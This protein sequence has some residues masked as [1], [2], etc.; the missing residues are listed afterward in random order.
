MTMIAPR[1]WP[2]RIAF[3]HRTWHG[4]IGV[5]LRAFQA[6]R[7]STRG[8][9]IWRRR[10]PSRL[11]VQRLVTQM[12]RCMTTLLVRQAVGAPGESCG[13]L[14]ARAVSL[15]VA[16]PSSRTLPAAQ[17]ATP[18]WPGPGGMAPT[19]AWRDRPARA[20]LGH[21][22]SGTPRAHDIV[23]PRA[24]ASGG[25]T[26]G[27]ATASVPSIAAR[28]DQ[29]TR[30]LMRHITRHSVVARHTLV[31][32]LIHSVALGWRLAGAGA[33]RQRSGAHTAQAPLPLEHAYRGTSASGYVGSPG[34][35]RMGATRT[36]VGRSRSTPVIWRSAPSDGN[37]DTSVPSSAAA[38]RA[39]APA[40]DASPAINQVRQGSP[41]VAVLSPGT[42]L[43]PA[44]MDRLAEDVMTRIERRVRIERERRGL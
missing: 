1:P 38:F 15:A 4:A 20:P 30:L 9:L 29:R 35:P 41:A 32:R 8:E 19:V 3:R 25:A 21:D 17:L 5:R 22:R 14:P 36:E 23:A 18:T 34:G 6:R 12:T 33:S 10:R 16:A 11:T 37:G 39:A 42:R 27:H 44:T 24:A 31:D 13:R 43:D 7:P 2:P 26:S 28:V 40:G